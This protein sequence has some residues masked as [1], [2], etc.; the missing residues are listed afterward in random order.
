M[1]WVGTER[2][3]RLRRATTEH[4]MS[5]LLLPA[6]GGD[7]VGDLASLVRSA[8][9]LLVGLVLGVLAVERQE[10]QQVHR[11]I[12]RDLGLPSLVMLPHSALHLF[13][14]EPELLARLRRRVEERLHALPLR[15]DAGETLRKLVELAS[16]GPSSTLS[17]QLG[18]YGARYEHLEQPV[19]ALLQ[20]HANFAVAAMVDVLHT[21]ELEQ[22]TRPP[23]RR[24][25]VDVLQLAPSG[26]A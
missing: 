5:D 2:G 17:A 7:T 18:L 4:R 19:H 20:R 24:A 3:E 22:L 15:A 6:P 16:L 1:E 11:V 13:A 9:Y 10:G 12:G 25:L 23:R 14:H 21:S 26:G 8:V